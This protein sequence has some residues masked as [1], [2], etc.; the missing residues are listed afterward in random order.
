MNQK[1]SP[2]IE[3]EE[4]RQVEVVREVYDGISLAN[5]HQ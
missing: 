5:K 4:R 3:V 1:I 2:K